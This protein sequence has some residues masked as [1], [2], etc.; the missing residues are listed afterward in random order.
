MVYICVY[1]YITDCQDAIRL[2]KHQKPIGHERLMICNLCTHV[3]VKD[4]AHSVG[5]VPLSVTL[6]V[7]FIWCQGMSY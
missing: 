3:Q 2:H 7:C 1:T 4:Q 5:T 6:Y